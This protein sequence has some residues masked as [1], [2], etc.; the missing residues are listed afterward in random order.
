[1][2]KILFLIL[3]AL[4]YTS[5]AQVS[6]KL[7]DNNESIKFTYVNQEL[8]KQWVSSMIQDQEGFMW[9]ATQDGLYR[10][11]GNKFLSFRYNPQNNNSLPANWVRVVTQDQNGIFWLG[12][13]GEGLVRFDQKKNTFKKIRSN[14]PNGIQSIIVYNIFITSANAIWV[15]GDDG[16]Y[17]KTPEENEFIKIHDKSINVFIN[18]TSIGEEIVVLNKT[19]YKYN[20]VNNKLELL[21]DDVALQRLSISSKNILVYRNNGKLFTH[22][23]KEDP[24]LIKLP[25]HIWIISN[26]QNDICILIG[27]HKMYKYNL[28]NGNIEVLNYN[29]SKFKLADVNSLYLDSQGI[30]WIATQNGLYKE[31]KAGKIFLNTIPFHARRIV[32]DNDKIYIGGEKGLHC[33]SKKDKTTKQLI[34]EKRIFSVLKTKEGIWA[35]DIF[36][37]IYFIDKKH[38]IKTYTLEKEHEK[39]LKVYGLV[40]DSNGFIWVSS[41]DCIYVLDNKGNLLHKF[42]FKGNNLNKELKAIQLHL[43]QKG[44]LWVLTVGNGLFIVPDIAE[45]SANKKTF[46]YNHYSHIDGDIKTLNSDV[47]YEIH[48]T[49]DGDIWIGSDFGINKYLPKIDAFEA[50]SIENNLFDKKVMAIE[51][52]DQ[53]FLWINTIKDGIFVYDT[54]NVNLINLNN[55]DGLISN[56]GLFT[57]STFN[58]GKMY[59][60]TDEGIQIMNPSLLVNPIVHKEPIINTLTVFGEEAFKMEGNKLNEK[61]IDLNYKQTDLSIDFSLHDYR[62]PQKVNYYYL[63]TNSHIDWRKAVNNS[64]SY[65]NL[66]PGEYQFKVK[67]SYQSFADSPIATLSIIVSPPWYKT[68]WAYLG[69]SILLSSL[70]FLFLYLKY[71]QQVTQNNLK[72]ISIL[73]VA[74]SRLFAS[75]SHEFR[76]PL[77]L[78]SGPIQKQLKKEG[79]EKGERNNLEMMQRNTERLLSLV[80]QLLD[81]SK[82]ES[83][84]LNLQIS[85]NNILS[86]IDILSKGFNFSADQK[87]ISYVINV[88]TK[89]VET[90]FDKD[91]V[92]KITINLLSN[93]IKYTPNKGAI[94]CNAYIQNKQFYFEVRNTGKGLTKNE[95]E[96]IFERFYQV[97]EHQQ[98]TGIGLSLVKDLTKLHKGTITVESTVNKWTVF[99]VVLPID[100]ASFSKIEI[101]KDIITTKTPKYVGI[102]AN[103]NNNNLEDLEENDSINSQEN[104]ILLIVED[105]ADLRTYVS[106]I[107]NNDY[108]ILQAQ[109]GQVGIDMAIE[110]VPDII[111]SDIMMP[112]KNGIELCNTLKVDERTSHIPIILL[113]A[114]IGDENKLEGIKTGADDY[115][116]KP[117]NHDLLL[118]KVKKLLENLK[119]LQERYSKEVVIKA[120]DVI[121]STTDELFLERIQAVLDSKLIEST[122]NTED[123]CKNVGMSRMQLHRKLKAFFGMTTSEFIRS[124]R[125]KLAAKL[126]LESDVNVSQIGYTVGFN[127][128][129]YFSKRFKEIYHC[130]PTEYANSKKK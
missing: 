110:H 50:L 105:N 78:I 67:A 77:T 127:D 49:K 52:D 62:F 44:N 71:K 48:E 117:F 4:Y 92:E 12:T 111:I 68:L 128:H 81:I 116:T 87:E 11:D 42:I 34:S 5:F 6:V 54:V 10:Y 73:N 121:I 58:N 96:K 72:A 15:V 64:V 57:S 118:L 25:E 125:L 104:P 45:I 98:G 119:K 40:E 106:S 14:K 120:S 82:I 69:I 124:E 51:T 112:I 94:I 129:A 53:N 101:S 47:L 20:K 66:K 24:N 18:E 30:L 122:F 97:D 8:S 9:F 74:K 61:I 91:V 85:K 126:L 79:L 13:Q 100:K 17:R 102:E 70:I 107:F 60:G 7:I 76:T 19:I 29:P 23:I 21:I 63:L 22:N 41:W 1:M 2:K 108:T 88:N 32:V 43:D 27:S 84:K 86:F 75:V 89:D 39:L 28:T 90:W 56:S 36:G 103:N 65:T 26:V 3:I 46:T 35:G 115:I 130:T 38:K 16:V 31:N 83:G 114:K 109:N 59:F 93:A 55:N 99:S 33:Y 37:D 80:D 123:F 95:T 113:T